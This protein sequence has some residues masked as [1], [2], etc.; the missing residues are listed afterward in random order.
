MRTLATIAGI[1]IFVRSVH[2]ADTLAQLRK[3]VE[4]IAAADAPNPADV[5]AVRSE[6]HK[7]LEADV[8]RKLTETVVKLLVQLP[9]HARVVLLGSIATGKYVDVLRPILG[10]W[11]HF[12]ADFIGR[13]DMS[14]GGLLLR[15]ARSGEPLT[16][17]RIDSDT[18]PR[19]KRPPKLSNI[20]Q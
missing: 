5:A 18:R 19:G 17:Q 8:D 7:A 11:L 13:G 9:P 4:A 10:D 20:V 1:C 14:R 15:H 2:A 12:P 6:L 16:Y 3:R